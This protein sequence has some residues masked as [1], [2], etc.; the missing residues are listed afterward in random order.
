MV[1]FLQCNTNNCASTVFKSFEEAVRIY[2]LPSRVR[3]DKGG[4]NVDIAWFMLSHPSRGPNRGSD[5]AGRSM[6]N[7]RIE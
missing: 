7:K 2:G 3:T 5:I 1:L 6:H 4:E